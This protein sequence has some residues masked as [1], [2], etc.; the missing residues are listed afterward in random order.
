MSFIGAVSC[1]SYIPDLGNDP[2]ASCCWVA[3]K[4]LIVLRADNREWNQKSSVNIMSLGDMT[5]SR[6]KGH[7]IVR[8]TWIQ[9]LGLSPASCRILGLG[10]SFLI[11]KMGLIVLFTSQDCGEGYMRQS[12]CLAR[13]CYLVST[14]L[15]TFLLPYPHGIV[16]PTLCQPCLSEWFSHWKLPYAMEMGYLTCLLF[17]S[18]K[19]AS[20]TPRLLAEG[21]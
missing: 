6:D 7:F 8:Q 5:G 13:G 20:Q 1:L 11:S 14:K 10:L 17:D 9:S 19:L 16:Q 3:P 12:R 15:M 2:Y 4:C 18:R 21:L